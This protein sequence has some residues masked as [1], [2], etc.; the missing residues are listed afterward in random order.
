[1]VVLPSAKSQTHLRDFPEDVDFAV[2]V[3][4]LVFFLAGTP[5]TLPKGFESASCHNPRIAVFVLVY[6]SRCAGQ[7][8]FGERGAWRWIADQQEHARSS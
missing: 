6:R 8:M 4:L 2:V 1:M 5:I 7:G 3:F